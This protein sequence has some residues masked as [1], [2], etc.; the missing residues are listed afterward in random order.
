MANEQLTLIFTVDKDGRRS[1]EQLNGKIKDLNKNV[2]ATD[3]SVKATGEGWASWGKAFQGAVLVTGLNQGLE[4]LGKAKQLLTDIAELQ[5][6]GARANRAEGFLGRRLEFQGQQLDAFVGKLKQATQGTL[7]ENDLVAASNKFIMAGAKAEEAM[8][9]IGLAWQYSMATGKEFGEGVEKAFGALINGSAE[10]AKALGLSVDKTKVLDTA[11]TA[12]GFA[13]VK[14]GDGAKYLSA[15]EE[16]L[17]LSAAMAAEGQDKLNRTLAN[18]GSAGERFLAAMKAIKQQLGQT[19]AGGGYESLTPKLSA[20]FKETSLEGRLK[21]YAAAQAEGRRLQTQIDESNARVEAARAKYNPGDWNLEAIESW[22][23]KQTAGSRARL[24]KF[25]QDNAEVLDELRANKDEW[26]AIVKGRVEDLQKWDLKQTLLDRNQSKAFLEALDVAIKSNAEKLEAA[27]V[28]GDKAIVDAL[29][30]EAKGL[31]LYKDQMVGYQKELDT[32]TLESVQVNKDRLRYL[33]QSGEFYSDEA[34]GLRKLIPILDAYTASK[35]E[36]AQAEALW[37]SAVAGVG[38]V[39]PEVGWAEKLGLGDGTKTLEA[40]KM[41]QGLTAAKQDLDK[42]LKSGTDAEQEQALV[43]YVNYAT[44]MTDKL[45]K[46]GVKTEQLTAL[47]AQLERSFS[48]LGFEVAS[49]V[50]KAEVTLQDLQDIWLEL[51]TQAIID[52]NPPP[53]PKPKGGGSKAPDKMADWELAANRAIREA[54]GEEAK[55]Y[56]ELAKAY[57]EADHQFQKS[58]DWNKYND[59]IEAATKAYDDQIKTLQEL[60]RAREVAFGVGLAND[61][62]T[63]AQRAID[64]AQKALDAANM[65]YEAAIRYQVANGDLTEDQAKALDLQNRIDAA[66]GIEKETLQLDQ[67]TEALLRTQAAWGEFGDA[68]GQAGSQIQSTMGWLTQVNEL[69]NIDSQWSEKTRVYAEQY[70]TLAG[71]IGKVVGNIGKSTKDI[72]VSSIQASGAVGQMFSTYTSKDAKEAAT[73]MGWWSLGQGALLSAFGDWPGAA[74]AGLAAGY[75]WLF[76]GQSGGKRN[77]VARSLGTAAPSAGGTGGNVTYQINIA[78]QVGNS[79]AEIGDTLIDYLKASARGGANP[80][81]N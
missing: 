38:A 48:T 24:A 11:A 5:A 30:G 41:F 57:E 13:V 35:K 44:E 31:K 29:E 22:E 18:G 68:I 21:A 53:K 3:K 64:D 8:V 6:E 7:S 80:W 47:N 32:A 54:V 20:V 67:Q 63:F 78:P 66:T 50:G 81:G 14:A 45:D 16:R 17:A 76:G 46:L 26:I 58:K 75:F 73:K 69:H 39:S 52:G 70:S 33:E 19:L 43:A 72:A 36:Q 34:E 74:A 49:K 55:A 40:I 2:D 59:A 60:A 9:G 42:A 28:V 1:V 62:A 25:R 37:A 12:A 61:S 65:H 71:G 27:K 51:D 4:L 77:H 15:E 10:G 79:P 23:A 56:A